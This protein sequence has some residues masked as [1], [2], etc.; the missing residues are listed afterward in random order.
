MMGLEDYLIKQAKNMKIKQL[1]MLIQEFKEYNEIEKVKILEEILQ[2]KKLGKR[3]KRK[4]GNYERKIAKIF[5]S[6]LGIELYRTPLSGGFAK[7]KNRGNDFKGDIVPL[8]DGIEFK[9]HI[10]AKD[11]KTW[12]LQEWINQAK[13]DCAED[14]IPV[15]IFHKY[16][17]SEDF[18]A[19]SL[20]DFFKIVDINK[21]IERKEER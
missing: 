19:L 9:L 21:I 1:E 13:E 18:I 12:K 7:S 20:A 8:E 15:V 17:T 5:K 16:N 6:K 2:K 14:K 10:E 11:H 3:S 4:G